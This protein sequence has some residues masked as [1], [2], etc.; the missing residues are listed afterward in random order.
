MTTIQPVVPSL[1]GDYNKPVGSVTSGGSAGTAVVGQPGPPGPPGKDSTV[2]GPPGPPGKDS[3][4]PGPMGPPGPT[5]VSADPNNL[6]I[7]GS[8]SLLYVPLREDPLILTL[9]ET[10]FTTLGTWYYIFPATVFPLPIRS[11]N[12][13]L[14]VVVSL[15]FIWTAGNNSQALCDWSLDGTLH[16]HRT[17]HALVTRTDDASC[18][19]VDLTFWA[20]VSGTTPT[21]ALQ[22]RQYSGPNLLS[23]V[24]SDTA[25]WPAL[26]SYAIIFD[27]GP[28]VG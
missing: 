7:L 14:Q 3:T 27:M 5:T 23:V 6:A 13:L 25:G 16:Y 2:P 21:V 22:G 20:I 19:D 8:D 11:G 18:N 9:K 15:Q 10:D 26:Q 12:S 28:M 17:Y 1:S 24:G 4:V